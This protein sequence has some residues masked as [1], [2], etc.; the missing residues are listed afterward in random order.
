MFTLAGMHS[1]YQVKENNMRQQYSM[2]IDFKDIDLGQY[3]IRTFKDDYNYSKNYYRLQ[4][5]QVYMG[6]DLTGEYKVLQNVEEWGVKIDQW[7]D[8]I[9]NDEGV[10]I[11][12][13][14][15]NSLQMEDNTD[16]ERESGQDRFTQLEEEG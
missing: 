15:E 3:V 1:W 10:Y 11:H 8:M 6:K 16:I 7:Q 12:D 13:V 4:L 9:E 5:K 2:N 14:D